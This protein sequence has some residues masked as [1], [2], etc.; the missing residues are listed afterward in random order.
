MPSAPSL[1]PDEDFLIN[2]NF[3]ENVIENPEKVIENIDNALNEVL[4]LPGIELWDPLINVLSTKADEDLQDDYI[5][6]N[7]LNKKRVEGIKDG[8]NFDQIKDTFDMGKAWIFLWQR[9]WKFF[10]CM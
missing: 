2:T 3:G 10:K 7:V 8:C 5:N 4:G 1:P 9:Q 6:D